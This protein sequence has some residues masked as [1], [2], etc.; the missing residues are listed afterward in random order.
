MPLPYNRPRLIEM[1]ETEICPPIL[2]QP[3][4]ALLTMFWTT[5]VKPFQTKAPYEAVVEIL[6]DVIQDIEKSS[7]SDEK[8]TDVRVVDCC[9]GAGG[10]MPLIE[11]EIK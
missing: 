6:E 3:I 5:Q 8:R 7:S 11:K 1:H 9:S 4:Q 10:P 2:R